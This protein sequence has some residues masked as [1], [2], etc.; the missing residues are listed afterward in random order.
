MVEHVITHEIG[1]AIGLCHTNGG[2]SSGVGCILIPGTP[3]MDTS[4][5]FNTTPP[6]VPTGEFSSGDV[7]ALN[8]LY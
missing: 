7:T 4:S 8:I 5:V 2:G 1:H 6:A 3:T